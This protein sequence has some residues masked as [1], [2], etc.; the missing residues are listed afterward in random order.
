[1]NQKEKTVGLIPQAGLRECR[2]KAWLSWDG[3][4][5]FGWFFRLALLA[6]VLM[7]SRRQLPFG[8]MSLEIITGKECLSPKGLQEV[9]R[10]VIGVE[11]ECHPPSRLG[12]ER[13]IDWGVKRILKGT[14]RRL[15]LK[16][17]FLA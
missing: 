13:K 3:K 15:C 17:G 4:L 6:P 12:E 2:I 16:V 10:R 14:G 1:M 11:H 8:T 5:E 7:L 9:R